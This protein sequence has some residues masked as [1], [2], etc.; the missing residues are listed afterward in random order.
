M[1][2]AQQ[3]AW[4]ALHRTPHL[5]SRALYRLIDYTDD[6]EAIFHLSAEHLDALKIAPAAQRALKQQAD[7]QQLERDL[8]QLTAMG[9]ELVPVNS[10]DYPELL[11]QINDPPPL[12]YIRGNKAL[13]NT[14]Q[15]AMVGS[16]R[17]SRQGQ[18]NAYRFAR[19]LAAKGFTITSGLALGID[20]AC[21]QGALASGGNTVAVLGTGVDVVYPAANKALFAELIQHG[22]LVS[23]FPLGTGPR[24]SLFPRRNRLISGMG[25]GVIVVEAALKSGSLITARFALE[26]G[27]EVFAIPGSIHSTASQGCHALIKQGAQLVETAQDVMEQLSGWTLSPVPLV[28]N[29]LSVCHSDNKEADAITETEAISDEEQHIMDLL[30]YDP[31]PIDLLQSRSGWAAQKISSVLLMLEMKGLVENRAGSY[32]RV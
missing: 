31:A 15:L 16:R 13:L 5:S 11:K 32:Q 23:E 6:P 28:E 25:L 9:V 2:L 21:H 19:E 17:T 24:R 22:A 27:R 12:L 29:K 3:R 8:A 4:L 30:G 18:E 7:P 10:S 14:P 20:A 1:Q 26:Q